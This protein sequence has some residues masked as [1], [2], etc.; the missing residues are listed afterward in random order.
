TLAL[1]IGANA[2]IF[3]VVN[4]VLLRP[5]SYQDPERLVRVFQTSIQRNVSY[6]A[7]SPQDFD[8]WR[9]QSTS[10]E[11]ISSY[12]SYDVNLT[13]RGDP[14]SV[15]ATYVSPGFFQTLSVAP[16]IGRDFLADEHKPGQDQVIILSYSLWQRRFDSD[17]KII[18]QTATL[19]NKPFTIVGVMPP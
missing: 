3:S 7:V 12:H 9:R 1:G 5:L 13:G 6:G 17:P 19:D 11:N 14:A 8:D 15:S 2:A 16:F 18:G 10:F 4:G